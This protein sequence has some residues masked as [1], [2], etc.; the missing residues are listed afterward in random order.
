MQP[1]DYIFNQLAA[2]LA[3]DTGTL[4]PATL[5][6]QLVPVKAPF[7]PGVGLVVGALTLADFATSTAISTIVGSQNAVQNPLTFE[8]MVEMKIPAGGWRWTVTALTNL[9]QTIYGVALL[10]NTL[11]I[12]YGAALLPTPILLTT[13]GQVVEIDNIQF[14]FLLNG[15]Y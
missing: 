8:R 5:P 7:T 10:D 3:A 9:P 12:V 4:A 14:V 1:T 6:P 15:I 2:L 13:V 11:A